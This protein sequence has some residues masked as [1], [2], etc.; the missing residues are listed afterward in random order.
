MAEKKTQESKSSRN[1]VEVCGVLKENKLSVDIDK[2]NGSLV[3]QYGKKADQQVEIG[4][5]VSAKKKDGD[6]NKKYDKMKDQ[7]ADF[8]SKVGATEENPATRLRLYGANGFTPQVKL[9]E[10][11]AEG[12]SDVAETLKVEM[13]FGNLYVG[14]IPSEDF[15]GTFEMVIYLSKAPI[16]EVKSDEETGRLLVDGYYI[17]HNGEIKPV[18]FVVEDEELVEAISDCEKGQ[19]IEIWGDIKIAQ[20]VE[21]KT[22][23][24]TFG[25][26]AKTDEKKHTTRELVITG[27]NIIDED[28]KEYISPSFVKAALVERA[29]FL[30]NLK[31][32]N[33]KKKDAPKG[34]GSMGGKPQKAKEDD[35]DIPF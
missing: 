10:Y 9:D 8:V 19:T 2:I 13:G 31:S 17:T 33:N 14:D 22:K 35:D 18:S 12:K 32:G 11:V 23:E 21:T 34:K 4:V 7:I 25:G 27:G 16:M 3:I 15:K 1:I 5:Y 30:E 26:K 24:S 6:A 20:I 29:N 28:S